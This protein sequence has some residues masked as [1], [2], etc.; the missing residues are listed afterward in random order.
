MNNG[1]IESLQLYNSVEK[2]VRHAR[3]AQ[4]RTSYTIGLWERTQCAWKVGRIKV[5][6]DGGI[7]GWASVGGGCV[8]LR[9][10][11]SREGKPL[12]DV[13]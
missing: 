6:P 5:G 9:G 8:G 10:R 11:D 3:N 7:D 12:S 2:D 4:R 13:S 1:S